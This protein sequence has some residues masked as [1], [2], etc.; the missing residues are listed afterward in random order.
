MVLQLIEQ[1]DMEVSLYVAYFV[2]VIL[3][4]W[5]CVIYAQGLALCDGW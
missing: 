2:F 4:G 5:E 3:L 1:K